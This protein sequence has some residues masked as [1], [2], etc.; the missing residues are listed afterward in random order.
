LREQGQLDTMAEEHAGGS[1]DGSSGDITPNA[2]ALNMAL[3][4]AGSEDAREFLR[5]QSAI[6]DKQGRLLDLQIEDLTREDA[7]R[8]W[9]LRVRHISDLMKLA[10]EVSVAF[11]V[12]AI[13]LGIGLT[14]WS[15]AHDD[16]L[17][18]EAFSIPP[19]M[20]ARGLTGQ[21]IA[22]Q[23]QD[24]LAAM[25]TA[26]DSARPAASYSSNWG[27]DI[28]VVIPDTGISINEFYRYLASSL[29]NQ[30]HIRGEVYRT[31][32]GIVIAARAGGD[33]GTKI[34]GAEADLD[35][36]LQESA[37][38]IY[39]QT[40]PYRYASFLKNTPDTKKQDIARGIY[41][42]LIAQGSPRD[43][44][45]AHVGLGSL[46][47]TSDPEQAGDE[48]RKAMAL[49]PGFAL[50]PMNLSNDEGMFGHD[51]KALEDAKIALRLLEQG[52][53]EFSERAS[54]ISLPNMRAGVAFVLGDFTESL[55]EFQ[56]VVQLPDYAQMVDG[57]RTTIPTVFALLH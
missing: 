7:V 1:R 25:Q 11:I 12:V 27:N 47:D 38:A 3:S 45:W 16:G 51:E 36:L 21:A 30:T 37:E 44:I 20:A 32:T 26:T 10:F 39:R 46:Q 49:A 14:V 43:R 9:S 18:I 22:A 28:K 57:A 29:G 33:G 42:D 52:D 13:A 56:D 15:A 23:L 24:K 8:H 35:K 54:R 17:V 48:E 34:A 41:E 6:A 31:A 2:A 19:D 53:A 50:P 4:G 40:Q 5:R 55:R